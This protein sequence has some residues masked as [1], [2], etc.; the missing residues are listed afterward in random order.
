MG[1][2]VRERQR[3]GSSRG[4]TRSSRNARS[5][6][7]A[8]VGA[9]PRGRRRIVRRQ[10]G[11]GCRSTWNLTIAQRIGI[12][13]TLMDTLTRNCTGYLLIALLGICLLAFPSLAATLE[14]HH[15]LGEA[16]QDGHQHSA[17]DLCSW[18]Q[19]H[20]SSSLV[21]CAPVL[22]S[23]PEIGRASCRERV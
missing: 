11:S 21:V 10:Y 15:A 3:R 16:D 20:A 2:D 18:V 22:A 12:I 19:S 1:G 23:E 8:R 7:R 17:A 13:P 6:R 5:R 9:S 4:R 14:L